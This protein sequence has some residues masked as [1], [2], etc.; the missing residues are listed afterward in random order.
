MHHFCDEVTSL[1]L[2]R[3]PT[4]PLTTM[5]KAGV[6]KLLFLYSVFAQPLKASTDE[7]TSFHPEGM[8]LAEKLPHLDDSVQVRVD[9]PKLLFTQSMEITNVVAGVAAAA[10]I[11]SRLTEPGLAEAGR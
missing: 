9:P 7:I 3:L 11:L 1:K 10:L 8:L 2:P 4:D 5:L 6:P